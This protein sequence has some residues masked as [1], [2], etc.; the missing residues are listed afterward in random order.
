MPTPP[1]GG[2]LLYAV[3]PR[4]AE[5]FPRW[6]THL[7]RA[8]SLEFDWIY[9][10]PIHPPGASGSLYAVADP[11]AI[12]DELLD[13][14]DPRAPWEQLGAL[15]AEA[16]EFGLK[17]MLEL[18]VTQVAAEAE[19]VTTR[20]S[21]FSRDASGALM[22]PGV[23][24]ARAGSGA[25]TWRDV[26]Q[27]ANSDSPDRDALW[28]LWKEVVARMIAAGVDGLRCHR[29]Y[30]IPAELCRTLIQHARGLRP[31]V[32]MAADTLGC[33]DWQVVEVAQLGFDLC[34]NS[35]KWWDFQKSWCLDQYRAIAPHASTVS[36]PESHDT[37]RLMSE[38]SGDVEAVKLRYLFA[39]LF[40]TGVAMPIGF[41]FGFRKKLAAGQPLRW[42][43]QRV[44]LGNFIRAV[45]RTKKA[46]RVFHEDNR[47]ERV[48]QMRPAIVVLKKESLDGAQRGLIV[49]NTSRDATLPVLLP[50]LRAL[51]GVET[52]R[53]V[54]PGDPIAGETVRLIA[55]L[56]PSGFRVYVGERA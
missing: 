5:S 11:L 39:A 55:P 48:S 33:P 32:V 56:P 47:V 27:V 26:V 21:W 4:L 54:T 16:H 52:P 15:V 3:F 35:S 43:K 51:L 44:D 1:P 7:A 10:N 46:Y 6:R 19:L 49:L 13:R 36:F 14:H 41:E 18:V 2:Y 8:A 17:V 40:S 37:E 24:G 28:G 25:P 20:P 30:Q 12:N 34:Y 45:N 53:D 22:H 29:A 31:D 38:L 50:D 23:T 42:E 9:V